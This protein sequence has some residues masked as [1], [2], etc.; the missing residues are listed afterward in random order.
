MTLVGFIT[1]CGENWKYHIYET[2]EDVDEFIIDCGSDGCSL[3][4][5]ARESNK[6]TNVTQTRRLENVDYMLN[7]EG[8]E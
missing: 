7:A 1:E 6:W 3:L 2:E 8:W 5:I 4:D